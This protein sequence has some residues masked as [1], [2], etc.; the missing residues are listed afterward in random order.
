MGQIGESFG[1]WHVRLMERMC[2]F[3]R[4][5]PPLLR[6]VLLTFLSLSPRQH[7]GENQRNV[8]TCCEVAVTHTER[9]QVRKLRP[10]AFPDSG[11]V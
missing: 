3:L 6:W 10:N 1:V 11:L 9:V 4:Y 7:D 2:Q 8:R 5:L